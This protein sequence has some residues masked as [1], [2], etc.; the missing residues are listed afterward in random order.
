MLSLSQLLVDLYNLSGNGSAYKPGIRKFVEDIDETD[1]H[2]RFVRCGD[3]KIQL[4][5]RGLYRRCDMSLRTGSGMM[6]SKSVA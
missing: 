2:G 1:C 3:T 4:L 6:T 5:R